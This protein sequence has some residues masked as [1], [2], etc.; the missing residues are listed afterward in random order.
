MAGQVL[1]YDR[2][3]GGAYFDDPIDDSDPYKMLGVE[4]PTFEAGSGGTAAPPA[5]APAAPAA[6]ANPSLSAV[7]PFAG[8]TEPVR[9][10]GDTT[11]TTTQSEQEKAADAAAKTAHQ[12]VKAI[13]P[14]E[15][16]AQKSMAEEQEFASNRT[17]ALHAEHDWVRGEAEKRAAAEMAGLTKQAAALEAT[18]RDRL[19]NLKTGWR[20]MST[21]ERIG[22]ALAVMVGG[23][24]QGLQ[25]DKGPNHALGILMS[26]WEKDREEAKEAIKRD[27]FDRAAALRGPERERLTKEG[28]REL[29]LIDRRYDIKGKNILEEFNA[30]AARSG[31]QQKIV[32]AQKL[33]AQAETK[34]QQ[35]E[36]KQYEG[37]RT[38]HEHELK[39]VQPTGTNAGKDTTIQDL[40]GKDIGRAMSPTEA[41]KVHAAR[42]QALSF[43]QSAN[44]LKA[45]LLKY[46]RDF[47]D[48]PAVQAERQALRNV[49]VGKM[50][51]ELMESGVLNGSEFPRNTE[52]IDTS[53]RRGG[54]DAAHAVDALA[55]QAMHG[56]DSVAR[57]LGR[58]NEGATPVPAGMLPKL[59]TKAEGG[60]GLHRSP[61]ASPA[62]PA[63]SAAA[64]AGKPKVGD[65]Q[66]LS[67]GR[68]VR[69]NGT[70]WEP[71]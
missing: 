25:G 9:L 28:E 44:D 53:V 5:P 17:A 6:N 16:A 48:D 69:F 26:S 52:I 33:S 32:E 64:P 63:A 58:L 51:K 20:S 19:A 61:P 8:A 67:S 55:A 11:T 29:G 42:G 47:N 68:A 57:G 3:R 36:T 10:T 39:E 22:A 70:R 23:L 41:E 35:E 21:G 71:Q 7:A 15:I 14:D 12:Q 56:Y 45:H 49:L 27:Y 37:L 1:R 31:S 50:S 38:K 54:A 24:G 65:T 34:F 59:S 66:T 40:N 62:A 18:G 30:L 60:F 46:G 43:I 4:A 13:L 2:D